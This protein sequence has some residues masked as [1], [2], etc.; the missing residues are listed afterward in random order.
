[1]TGNAGAADRIALTGVSARGH[2]GVLAHEKRDGQD[3]VVD[4]VL[5]VDLAPAASSDDL[6][7]TINY[8]EVAADVVARIEGPSLDLIEA[9][10]G[11]IADDALARRG[12]RAVEVTV[13]KPQAPVGV[14]FGDVAVTLHRRREAQRAVIS[15]GSNQPVAQDAPLGYVPEGAA[16][17]VIDAGERLASLGEIVAMSSVYRTAPVGG[18]AQEDFANAVVIVQTTLT[19]EELLTDLQAIEQLF[20]RTREVRWGPRSL[21]LDLISY[22][23]WRDPYRSTDPDLTVPHPRAHERAFVLVPWL[24]ADPEARLPDAWDG[25]RPL[26]EHLEGVDTGDLEIIGVMTNPQAT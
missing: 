23:D 5:H 25:P 12:V 8:A 1:M 18:V 14:P 13:H 4:V 19:P 17:T 20:G 22:G 9:L 24:E 3:F 21:D 15:L 2:H 7:L 11:Q 26:S 16:V 6:D 10:A